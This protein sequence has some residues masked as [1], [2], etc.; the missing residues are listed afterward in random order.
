MLKMYYEKDADINILKG[1]KIAVIGYGSQGHA[2][3]Q[4][5]RESGMEVVVSTRAGTP[6]YQLAI[7]HGFKPLSVDEAA[8]QGDFIQILM[9][10]ETQRAVYEAQIKPHLKDGKTLCFSHGFNIHFGQV[11]PPSNIDVIMVAP[12]G[13]G[14]LVRSEFEKGGGVPCLMAIH[15]NATGK[16]RE[17]AMAYAHGIGGTRAGVMETTFAEETETD[18]FGEQA[19]LCGGAAALVKA[20]FETLVEAGYQPELAYFECMHELKLIVDLFYQGGLSYMRYSI[21]NTAEYGDLTRGP[22]IVTEE[23]K[24]EMKRILSEIQSGRFAREWILENQAGRPVFNALEK[25]DKG[26]LIEKVGRELRKMM[27]WIN[28]KEV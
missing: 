1:K 21:S 25:K 22:R 6:N 20:G 7:K 3:A 16:A 23:T 17:K 19:V 9:P 4:N 8:Q 24:K 11:V 14:H 28:A 10:D 5:L 18:L 2:Q 27:K 26:H 12:K 13:P 15:Q